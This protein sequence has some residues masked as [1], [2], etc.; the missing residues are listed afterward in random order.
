MF[1]VKK[2]EI[3]DCNSEQEEVMVHDLDGIGQL[4]VLCSQK[5]YLYQLNLASFI[6]FG[7]EK[8]VNIVMQNT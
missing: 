7:D 8:R 5:P 1:Q 2:A 4:I 6:R 3:C